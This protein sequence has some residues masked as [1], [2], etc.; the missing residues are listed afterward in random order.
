MYQGQES[1]QYVGAVWRG[2]AA[3]PTATRSPEVSDDIQRPLSQSWN[4]DSDLP[5][6]KRAQGDL[7]MEDQAK[8]PVDV[9]DFIGTLKSLSDQ[10]ALLQGMPEVK[11][12]AR[13]E[14]A[15]NDISKRVDM[16]REQ[17]EEVLGTMQAIERRLAEL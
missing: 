8:P 13:L 16:L 14:S 7:T 17:M 11:N 4:S 12:G 10:A 3:A 9:K 5:V 2:R 1:S 6:S 15:V